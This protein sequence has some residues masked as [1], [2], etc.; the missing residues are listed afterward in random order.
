MKE[1]ALVRIA[2]IGFAVLIVPLVVFAERAGI[3][4]L[5]RF[6]SARRNSASRFLEGC[7]S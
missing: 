4:V 5:V 3:L 1:K 6:T 7:R 2:D